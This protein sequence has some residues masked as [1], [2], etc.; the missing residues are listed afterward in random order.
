MNLTID[1]FAQNVAT[2]NNNAPDSAVSR[3]KQIKMSGDS[4]RTDEGSCLQ[5]KVPVG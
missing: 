1:F 4:L 5:R 3:D 2:A